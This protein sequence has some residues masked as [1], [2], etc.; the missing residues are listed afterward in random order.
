MCEYYHWQCDGQPLLRTISEAVTIVIILPRVVRKLTIIARITDT[1]L[2]LIC[3]VIVITCQRSDDLI[4]MMKMAQNCLLDSRVRVGDRDIFS[5]QKRCISIITLKIRL[6]FLG[7]NLWTPVVSP[8][9]D[10]QGNTHW[11]LQLERFRSMLTAPLWHW[12]WQD[13]GTGKLR[14]TVTNQVGKK[15]HEASRF[16]CSVLQMLV[17]DLFLR[18]EPTGLDC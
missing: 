6:A 16:L 2:I 3:K 4:S 17:S 13:D 15:N 10:M 7:R 14:Q 8:S 12:H 9:R 1:V 18:L 11:Q 5:K